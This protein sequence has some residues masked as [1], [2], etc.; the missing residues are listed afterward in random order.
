MDENENKGASRFLLTSLSQPYNPTPNK[1][2]SKFK[3]KHT[4]RLSME[5]K[6]STFKK[7]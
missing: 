2:S 5:I 3:L 1:L 4:A 7:T 6:Y